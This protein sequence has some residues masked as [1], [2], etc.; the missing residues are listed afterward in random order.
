MGAQVRERWGS[1]EGS[2][3]SGGQGLGDTVGGRGSGSCCGG[4]A[5][6]GGLNLGSDDWIDVLVFY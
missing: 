4:L 6:L 1:Q 2:G 5:V 3:E